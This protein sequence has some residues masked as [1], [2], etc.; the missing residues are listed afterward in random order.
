MRNITDNNEYLYDAFIS[1]RHTELDQFVAENLHRELESFKLPR[2][3]VKKMDNTNKDRI[4]RVFRDRDELPIASNLADPITQALE[5]SEFLL[6]IC[7]P[8]LLESM[9][10]KKEIELFIQ[11]HDRD[12]VLAILIEGEPDDSFPDELRFVENRRV[13]ADG[14]VTEERIPVEPLAADVRGSSRRE[15]RKKIKEEVIRLAA[16]MFDCA[17]DELKQRHRERRI[18]KMLTAAAIGSGICLV[19]GAIST[20]MALRIQGQN[21]EISQKAAEILAQSEEIKA[22]SEEIQKQ[23]WA[24]LENYALGEAE[25][26]LE[27]LDQGD[28]IE[29]IRTARAVLPD[30]LENPDIPYTYQA[31]Y[32]LSKSLRLYDSGYMILPHIMLKHDTDVS[33]CKISPDEN[34]L[35][36]MDDTGMVSLWDIKTGALLIQSRDY[37]GDSFTHEDRFDFLD[38]ETFLYMGSNQIVR[39]S[40]PDQT[41]EAIETETGSWMKTDKNGGNI[42]I[43]D[44]GR[45]QIRNGESLEL[46]AEHRLEEGWHA[47]IRLSFDQ[48]GRRLAFC[49]SQ[50]DMYTPFSHEATSVFVMDCATGEIINEFPMRQEDVGQMEFAGDY[51][52][53]ANYENYFSSGM[54][55]VFNEQLEGNIYACDLSRNEVKWIFTDE[56]NALYDVKISENPDSQL[57]F[58]ASYSGVYLLNKEDGSLIG[59]LDLAEGILT[60]TSHLVPGEDYFYVHT[61]EGN[62]YTVRNNGGI[63]EAIGIAHRLYSPSNNLKYMEMIQGNVLLVPYSSTDVTLCRTAVG[64]NTET[65]MKTEGNLED[66]VISPDGKSY[67]LRYYYDDKVYVYDAATDE[68]TGSM[69]KQGYVAETVFAGKDNPVIATLT[70]DTL[71]LNENITGADIAQYEMAWGDCFFLGEHYEQVVSI[72]FGEAVF[73]EVM[74]GKETGRIEA[75]NM[76]RGWSA[77]NVSGISG[78]LAAA[79]PDEDRLTI[80]RLD[81][82]SEIQTIPLNAAYIQEVFFERNSDVLY[83]A[84]KDNSIEAYEC[85]ED[86]WSL[87]HSYPALYYAV[88]EAVS[89]GDGNR[90]I[91]QGTSASYLL[92]DSEV[93]AEL[94]D[95]NAVTRRQPDSEGQY[96]IYLGSTTLYRTPLYEYNMLM[97]AAEEF[98]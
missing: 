6:V 56:L 65:V 88:S 3:L 85:Q 90:V 45:V 9:W 23:Y 83:V 27:L 39:F 42:A 15:V 62:I 53:I 71:Y 94:Y 36:T 20:T 61:R 30:S 41:V 59:M 58:C 73:Y 82:M 12:H 97:E 1:Y 49:A 69:T 68:Q 98:K 43:I 54:Q 46:I 48:E 8:R 10:C 22:Q 51:L 16:P 89:L 7:S 84:Y 18:R 37:T 31:E 86:V 19:F 47:G 92:K 13:N 93:V 5:A 95:F 64:A 21:I 79:Y 14:T 34:T 35:M 70:N 63:I 4:N 24:A 29:A 67:L 11:L 57:V 78:H 76:K 40:I 77:F 33:I 81:D 66:M 75:D 74:T 38:S 17:Y 26:A 50:G 55:S 60:V 72:G 52:Y 91:L 44:D 96:I 32:A 25:N 80:Y 2:N 87:T 28:R